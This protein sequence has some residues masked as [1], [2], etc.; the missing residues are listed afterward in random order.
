MT[1]CL[2]KPVKNS[3]Q[4]LVKE[5]LDDWWEVICSKPVAPILGVHV[6]HAIVGSS[7]TA[8][9]NAV[10]MSAP[11]STTSSDTE[12][13]KDVTNVVKKSDSSLLCV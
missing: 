9:E 7:T 10:I 4:K 13:A 2:Y 8:D 12:Q 3:T 1:P 6:K 11:A 5:I